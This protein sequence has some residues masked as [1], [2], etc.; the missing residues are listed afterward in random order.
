MK[1]LLMLFFLTIMSINHAKSP[2]LCNAATV[3]GYRNAYIDGVNFFNAF[4]NF[5]RRSAVN[6]NLTT[7]DWQ[8]FVSQSND[9]CK[10]RY[11][12]PAFYDPDNDCRAMQCIL[13]AQGA[14]HQ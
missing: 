1:K 10:K 6:V 9:Y 4:Q 7:E 12:N 11:K 14:I 13:G 2:L 3:V 8:I 5:R